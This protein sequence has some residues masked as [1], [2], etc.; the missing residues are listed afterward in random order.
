MRAWIEHVLN[1]ITCL[2]V[3]MNRNTRK[4]YMTSE[5]RLKN[6]SLSKFDYYELIAVIIIIVSIMA[7]SGVKYV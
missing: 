4:D 1:Q 7:L 5:E 2:G 6:L 3:G